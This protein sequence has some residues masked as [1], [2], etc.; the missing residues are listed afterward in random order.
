MPRITN[1]MMTNIVLGDMHNNLARML[2]MQH[3]IATN[4]KYDRPS[5]NPV[6]VVR[7]LS[8]GTNIYENSQFIRNMDDGMTWLKN[9]EGAFN[10]ITSVAQRIRELAI[11]AGNGALEGVDMDAIATEMA[12]LQEELR[13][14]ANF[15]VA[16]RYLLGGLD[17]TESPFVRD[18]NGS[19]IYR[20]NEY[21]AEFEME[22]GVI[23]QVSFHGREIFPVNERQY[24]IRGTEVPLDFSWQGRPEIL[25]FQV[26]DRMAK[27]HLSELWGDDNFNGKD[28]PT[29]S[30]QFRDPG[31]LRGKTLKEI[32]DHIQ[33]SLAMGDV[34]RLVSVEAKSDPSRGV[35]WLEIRGHTGEP[36]RV[37]SW[38]ETDF[39]KQPDAVF[40]NEVGLAG[41]W[42]AGSAGRINITADNGE[43]GSV[44]VKSGDDLAAVAKSI[45][46]KTSGLWAQVKSDGTRQ[47]LVL[48]AK[49]RERSFRVSGTGGAEE[50]FAT[51]D[52]AHPTTPGGYPVTATE[53]LSRRVDTIPGVTSEALNPPAPGVAGDTLTFTWKDGYT[54]TL[55]LAGGEDINAVA[56]GINGLYDP[57]TTPGDAGHALWAEVRLTETGARQL[58]VYAIEGNQSFEVSA[59]GAGGSTTQ[60]FPATPATRESTALFRA[61]EPDHSHLDFSSLMRLETSVKSVEVPA[62]NGLL[63]PA[64]GGDLHFHLESG[65]RQAE[66]IIADNGATPLTIDDL[67]ARLR[68]VAGSWLEVTVE[69]D[70]PEGNAYDLLGRADANAEPATKRLVLRSK[71]G[72]GVAIFDH[73]S[74]P[75]TGIA[76]VPDNRFAAQWGL[77]T[78]TYGAGGGAFPTGST[79]D[80]YMPALMEVSVGDKVYQVKLYASGEES[81]LTGGV[82]DSSKLAAQIQKQVGSDILG[83]HVTNPTSASSPFALYAKTGEPLRIV[84]LPFADPNVE[85]FSGGL[86]RSAGLAT[87]VLG[88]GVLDT[89]TAGEAGLIRI[90]TGAKTI[91]VSVRAT[92]TLRDLA[93]RIKKEAGEWVDVAYYDPHIPNPNDPASGDLVQLSLTSKDGSP[94]SVFDV[95]GSGAATFRIDTALRSTA[96]VS[97][98]TAAAGD[99]LTLKVDGYEHTID[100]WDSVAGAPLV[101]G[102]SIDGLVSAINARFQGKDVMAEVVDAGGGDK[103]LVL[104]SPRG[105]VVEVVG[106][107]TQ[108]TNP[109][110]MPPEALRSTTNVTGWTAAAGESLDLTVDGNLHTI[111][112]T[113]ATDLN[114]LVDAINAEFQ[115]T[116]A[117]AEIV[118]AGGGVRH[119]VISSPQGYTITADETGLATALNLT[120]AGAPPHRRG[121][122]GPM[123][124]VT[125]VRT[126]ANQ[127]ATDFFGVMEDLVSAV[128]EEDRRGI[129]DSLLKRIDTFMD[130]LMKRRTQAGA[131]I[132]RYETSQRR[133][134]DNNTNLTDLRSKVSEPDL[135]EAL[136]RFN[137][138]QAVYQASL[139]T[140]AR[141]VQP[142]L[143]DFLK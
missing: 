109:L 105:Y 82:V 103:R 130:N 112:L 104:S 140:I 17:V 42:T 138:A 95:S 128:R 136:T 94:L 87:G 41:A 33:A 12:E 7:D 137:M 131:M 14:S 45:N 31:E 133:L 68:G 86:A 47:T 91:E 56:A 25:Q 129:S 49:D 132:L 106:A 74:G 139:S 67:A 52:Y 36:V 110:H 13:N 84:D 16:G 93:H 15:S 99:R 64:G 69:S 81:I 127:K 120:A 122:Q 113:G 65:G 62:T 78:A 24:A 18:E 85:D 51:Y 96:N 116:G 6:D 76:P 124:Q 66:L 50:L 117:V 32:A 3:Q 54:K 20:G 123:N 77:S 75:G 1:P 118:D 141:I 26:G 92:D 97:G 108:L 63:R 70:A 38:P 35:Q 53:R 37:T 46:E 44:D 119:L 57:V 125:T 143:V 102:Q 22:R 101:A 72:Q 115:G 100:L 73:D 39:V 134:T 83:Y 55:T 142:T 5:D 98:W 79:L 111:A 27:V 8:L 40:S 23:G 28:D 29:D 89:A 61:Q 9:S 34:G 135:A 2:K 4:K 90:R 107:R 60:Y 121:G 114:G 126:A 10:H 30:N 58:F 71:D 80:P 59:D 11:Y 48:Y 21:H 88:G 43:L 19:V